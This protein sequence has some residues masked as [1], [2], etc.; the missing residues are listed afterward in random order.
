MDKKRKKYKNSRIFMIKRIYYDIQN[1]LIE[2]RIW[3][4]NEISMRAPKTL[5]KRQGDIL[6]F[7][8]T[9]C[10]IR[11]SDISISLLIDIDNYIQEAKKKTL[12]SF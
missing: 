10:R 6:F 5:N 4:M 9:G 3:V 12:L 1:I 8:G 7:E 2:D 11:F